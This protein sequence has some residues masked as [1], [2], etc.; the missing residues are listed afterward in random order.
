MTAVVTQRL[1]KNPGIGEYR[2][3]P[4][5]SIQAGKGSRYCYLPDGSERRVL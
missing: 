1:S 2:G 4:I 5:L 3:S